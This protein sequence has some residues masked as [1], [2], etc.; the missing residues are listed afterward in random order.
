MQL[1]TIDVSCRG[2]TA[3]S[4]WIIPGLLLSSRYPGSADSDEHQC[5]TRAI[6]DCGIEVFVN[7]MTPKEFTHF[8]PYEQ[9]IRQYALQDSRNVEFISFPIGDQF[10]CRDDE[11]LLD[12][13]LNLSKR[14]KE[15]HQKILIHCRGGHG[16][17]GTIMS[18]LIGILFNLEAD[19]AMNHNFLSQQQRLRIKGR[20]S[21]MHPRQCEQVRKVLKMYKDQQTDLINRE[22]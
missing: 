9:Q 4:H 22:I 17:T 18:I 10:I 1:N 12:F 21:P 13:C 20:T 3:T 19:D 11:K 5:I 6:Y 15:D 14:I 2:P 7:L 16:R 8:T